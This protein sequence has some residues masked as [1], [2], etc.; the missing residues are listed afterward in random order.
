M[1]R[2]ICKSFIQVI[3][4]LTCLDV[5]RWKGKKFLQ[6]VIKVKMAGCF[7]NEKKKNNKRLIQFVSLRKGFDV[8]EN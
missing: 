1:E 2:K 7:Q 8:C 3:R 5:S 6:V 4:R